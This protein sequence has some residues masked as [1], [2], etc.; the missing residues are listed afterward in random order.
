MPT[1]TTTSKYEIECT[2]CESCDNPCPVPLPPPPPEVICPPPPPP[3]P[4]TPSPP[5]PIVYPPPPPTY[6]ECP[7]P[8]SEPS[9]EVCSHPPP[10]P[11]CSTCTP[12]FVPNPNTPLYE[13]PPVGGSG[14]L[15]A[16]GTYYP[17]DRVPYFPYSPPSN[18]ADS[19]CLRV[20]SIISVGLL[21]IASFYLIKMLN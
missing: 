2:M 14:G 5:P 6:P 15:V 17:P 9:C 19:A 20:R 13:T 1:T 8:P 18:S 21:N 16:G 7:P 11:P 12:S 4:P 10:L 3:L